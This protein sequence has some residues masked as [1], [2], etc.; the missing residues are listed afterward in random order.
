[1]ETLSNDEI[2]QDVCEKLQSIISKYK[3]NPNWVLPKLRQIVVT[4][5][6]T[7]DNFKGGIEANSFKSHIARKNS[8]H[9]VRNEISPFFI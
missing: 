4:R 8:S 5:W 2:A 9:S 3:Q 1:M 6:H 7:N